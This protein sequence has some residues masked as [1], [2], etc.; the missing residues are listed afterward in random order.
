MVR[1]IRDTVVCC[2][3][4][5]ISHAAIDQLVGI[6]RRSLDEALPILTRDVT[7]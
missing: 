5:I 6:I 2:P 7:A 3:P 4:L 1:G